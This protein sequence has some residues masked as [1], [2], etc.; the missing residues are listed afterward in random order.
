MDEFIISYVG[1]ELVFFERI[2]PDRAKP[3]EYYSLRI[4]QTDLT[5]QSRVYGGYCSSHPT[6]LFADM[7]RQWDGWKGEL[8]WTSLE[9][10]LTLR[11][12]H[13]GL[14]HISIRAELRSGPMSDDWRVIATAFADA[15]QL[16]GI[17]RRAAI[18]FGEPSV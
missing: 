18:F 4:L 8:V 9:S 10:E 17:A 12:S 2:P 5:A 13:D 15:G 6:Q 14:G 3:L 1:T 11:C 16:E 7:A